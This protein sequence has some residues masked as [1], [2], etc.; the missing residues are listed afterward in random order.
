MRKKSNLTIN[1]NNTTQESKTLR[2]P[3]KVSDN[4]DNRQERLM[5]DQ[6]KLMK[7]QDALQDPITN[8]EGF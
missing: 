8:Y 7:L 3:K 1:H 6:R 5:E 4:I 2:L